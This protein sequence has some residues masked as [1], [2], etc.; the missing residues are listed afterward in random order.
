M[1]IYL[2]AKLF[3]KMENLLKYKKYIEDGIEYTKFMIERFKVLY[4]IDKDLVNKEYISHTQINDGLSDD[5]YPDYGD[6]KTRH[7]KTR[8]YYKYVKDIKDM[9]L[10]LDDILSI[11][12]LCG[13]D[14]E[15]LDY[16]FES[17]YPLILVRRELHMHDNLQYAVIPNSYT[18]LDKYINKLQKDEQNGIKYVSKVKTKLDEMTKLKEERNMSSTS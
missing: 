2:N 7:E 12:I 4:P 17:I 8:Q 16:Y 10:D 1:L 15:L 11:Q 6:F 18:S 5:D 13:D 3:I 9:K 14:R